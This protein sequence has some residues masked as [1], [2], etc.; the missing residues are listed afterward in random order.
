MPRS[1]DPENSSDP[2][3]LTIRQ[4]GHPDTEAITALTREAYSAWVAVIG[5]EPLPM[6][7]DYASALQSDRFDPLF[8]DGKLV[9][10]IQTSL[11]SDTLTV[12][13]VAVSAARQGQ[14]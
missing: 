13:N 14:G 8:S 9:G 11:G 7:V 1:P 2:P 10:L 6:T 12:V 5:R 3:A 4:A